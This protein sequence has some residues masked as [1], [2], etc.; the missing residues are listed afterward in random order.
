MVI[1]ER[2]VGWRN[3][4]ELINFIAFHNQI[5]FGGDADSFGAQLKVNIELGS[6]RL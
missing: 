2:S 4:T 5:T 6:F 3:F 1:G